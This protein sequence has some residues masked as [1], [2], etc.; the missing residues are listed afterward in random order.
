MPNGLVERIAALDWNSL[1][2]T[3][4]EQGYAAIPT[5][6]DKDQCNEIIDTYGEEAHFRS[7]IDMARYRF[8]SGEYKY[9]QAP[10]P[11]LLQQL[12]E[13]FYPEL[14]KTANRWLEQLGGDAIYPAA[15]PEFLERCHQ[16]GQL[17]STP[18][19]LKYEEGGY[20]CL[21]QDLYGEV[22]FP[23]QVVFALNQKEKDYTGGEFLL[24]EQ[25]PRAQSRGHV[26][27]LEQGAGLIFP[28]NHR[29]VLG[30]RGY[31]KTTLRHGVSTITSGI[32]YSLGIIFHDAK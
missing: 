10:L 14:A 15:L 28:T 17:R 1:Q 24:I 9:Y 4:D 30:S 20:N 27:T 32:R 29:P 8:G 12:R 23:F 26:I 16:Q 25:R 22:F 21:H 31:Y 19:I 2:Q 5:L 3:L 13:G 18:L 11:A 7:T 6:L